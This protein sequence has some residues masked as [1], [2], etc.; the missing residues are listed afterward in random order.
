MKKVSGCNGRSSVLVCFWFIQSLRGGCCMSDSDEKYMMKFYRDLPEGN[1]TMEVAFLNMIASLD[2]TETIANRG[3]AL[4]QVSSELA[5]AIAEVK[6]KAIEEFA[7][8]NRE[9]TLAGT[10][11]VHEDALAQQKSS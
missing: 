3:V 11:R 9:T 7:E 6:Q 4:S 10:R 2:N 8:K 1:E 5:L